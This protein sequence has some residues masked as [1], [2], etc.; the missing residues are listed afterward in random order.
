[1]GLLHRV[2]PDTVFVHRQRYQRNSELCGDALDEWISQGFHAAAASGRHDRRN[3]CS[4]TLP[5]IACKHDLLGLG[6]PTV[7][8][9]MRGSR[10]PQRRCADAGGPR[11]CSAQC[12]RL[13]QSVQALCDERRL[14]WAHRIIELE[15]DLDAARFAWRRRAALGF[16]RDEGAAPHLAN[17]KTSPQQFSVDPTC[18][19]NGDL[20]FPGEIALGRQA[21]ARLE[22]AIGDFCSDGV[23]QFQI[24]ESWHDCT[25]NNMH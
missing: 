23:G 15:I 14:V 4:D 13:L 17:D 8:R 9:Q 24:F 25:E 6:R 2:G 20:A 7:L 22:P 10:V 21:I 16:A 19:G 3:R 5:A 12:R 18:G 11:Q 1:M